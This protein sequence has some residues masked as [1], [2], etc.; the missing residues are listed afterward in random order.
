MLNRIFKHQVES[1]AE[2]IAVD[3][4][5]VGDQFAF[6]QIS[7][8]NEVNAL[9]PTNQLTINKKFYLFAD[10]FGGI[11]ATKDLNKYLQQLDSDHRLA[12]AI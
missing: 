9:R 2:I 3:F 12:L 7:L 4:H 6:D 10:V 11:F 8:R 5:F 1:I